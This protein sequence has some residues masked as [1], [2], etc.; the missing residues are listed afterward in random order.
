M[1][2]QTQRAGRYM[3][4]CGMPE[5]EQGRVLSVCSER[6]CV[7]GHACANMKRA[8][9]RSSGTVVVLCSRPPGSLKFSQKF[10]LLS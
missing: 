6:V 7:T 8:E 5:W 2:T 9:Q 1:A 10:C 4:L 3:Q